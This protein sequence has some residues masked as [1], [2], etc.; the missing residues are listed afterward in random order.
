MVLADGR[1]IALRRG[2]YRAKGLKLEICAEDGSAIRVDLPTYR[3]PETK[4]T[5]GYYAAPDMDAVDLVIGSDGTLGVI[6]ELELDLLPLP[7]YIWGVTA[8]LKTSSRRSPTSSPC[9][10]K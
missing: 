9:A 6:T 3:M 10:M 1:T 8:F 5:S 2:Q 4:N 7:P